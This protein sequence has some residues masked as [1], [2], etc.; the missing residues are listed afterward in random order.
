[1]PIR[2]D[3]LTCR[4]WY[5]APDKA[6]GKVVKCPGCGAEL[7]VPADGTAIASAP[8]AGGASRPA[9]TAPP[10]PAPETSSFEDDDPFSIPGFPSMPSGNE[11]ATPVPV[12]ARKTSRMPAGGIGAACMEMIDW[13]A[14][15]P[16]VVA[17]LA[18]ALMLLFVGA[19]TERRTFAVLA[20][21]ALSG[22]GIAALGLIFPDRP[23]PKKRP[24]EKLSTLMT[25]K[26][27]GG[28]VLALLI[29]GWEVGSAL[30]RYSAQLEQSGQTVAPGAMAAAT[31]R[32]MVGVAAVMVVCMGI[33]GTLL[34]TV[35]FGVF[36][37][38]APIYLVAGAIL[39][40]AG[41]PESPWNT[42]PGV[43]SLAKAGSHGRDPLAPIDHGK[44]ISNLL[45]GTGNSQFFRQYGVVS[46]ES[47]RPELG[48]SFT[49]FTPRASSAPGQERAWPCVIIVPAGSDLLSGIHPNEDAIAEGQR[50]VDAGYV[51][52]VISLAD[53]AWGD[54]SDDSYQLQAF[55][56][57]RLRRAGLA[58]VESTLAFIEQ[59][60]PQVDPRRVAIVGE[61]TGGTVALLAAESNSA[62]GA[63]LVFAPCVDVTRLHQDGFATLEP[64][65]PGVRK[66]CADYSPINHV[67]RFRPPLFYFQPEGDTVIQVADA[68][69]F[70]TAMK[71][72]GKEVDCMKVPGGDVQDSMISQG[73]PR[74]IQWLDATFARAIAPR[75]SAAPR[76]AALQ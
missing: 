33:S 12:K 21:S 68:E 62:I 54:R 15:H 39:L 64:R 51:T 59:S 47:G 35:R 16:L 10:L 71:Q 75:P 50:W 4:K 20:A 67:D 72:A 28:I 5:K 30:L 17:V 9:P 60:L 42:I 37:V 56:G 44:V 11:P 25:P 8:K 26:L 52:L 18:M 49:L 63:C 22:G 53:G 32:V 41:V 40:V 66:F 61:G 43:A 34:A 24:T 74:A 55:E 38:L 27:I 19:A 45:R 70:V 57:M 1:M 65:F 13:V 46:S 3:C 58:D 14:C 23:Q 48:V 73:I 6:A 31:G 69:R 76:P 7:K 29:V 2:V 36:R